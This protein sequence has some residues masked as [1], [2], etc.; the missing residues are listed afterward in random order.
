MEFLVNTYTD[1]RQDNPSVESLYDGFVVSW[2]S[3]NQVSSNSN[4]DVISQ[5]YDIYGN[6]IGQEVQV[7]SYTENSQTAPFILN[8]DG[9]IVILWTSD[10][11]SNPIDNSNSGVFSQSLDSNLWVLN[12][13]QNQTFL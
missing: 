13:A 7:N 11:S 9:D 8:M 2:A 3:K 5:K 1:N 12:Q 10:A 4:Y 6:K